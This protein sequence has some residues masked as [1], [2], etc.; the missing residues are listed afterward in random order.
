MKK[1]QHKFL[2]ALILGGVLAATQTSYAVNIT[3]ND[4][5]NIV[6]S[7]ATPY[8]NGGPHSTNGADRE[9]NEVEDGE[10][11]PGAPA[12]PE[13]TQRWDLE[14][15]SLN[16]TTKT[17][18]LVGGFN[19]K[20]GV[21]GILPG[22][23]FIKV[24]GSQPGVGNTDFGDPGGT[25]PNPSGDPADAAYKNSPDFGY[26]YAIDLV[27]GKVFKLDG[28]SMLSSV[29]Y[30]FYKSNPWKYA[31]DGSAVQ[32][33][34]VNLNTQFFD[35]QTPGQVVA[36]TGEGSFGTLLGDS[37]SDTKE[38]NV[39]NI[40]IGDFVDFSAGQTIWVSYA[41]QCGNDMIK[42]AYSTPEAGSTALL[43]GA[44][45]AGLAMLRRRQK[46]A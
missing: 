16:T 10:W 28:N 35:N 17:L 44:G 3:I 34:G 23:V 13:A 21:D 43:I 2:G 7:P 45:F 33:S 37:G 12:M 40:D 5:N 32:L 9:D 14:G 4:P 46:S 6:V 38:H 42:G 11:F 27:G 20:T 24:G 25:P 41:E 19:F 29:L 8:F 30:D 1:N 15:L 36:D 22:H 18:S 39:V 26:T 31:E